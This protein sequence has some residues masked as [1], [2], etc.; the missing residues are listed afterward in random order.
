MLCAVGSGSRAAMRDIFTRTVADG[1]VERTCSAWSTNT[2]RLK[3]EQVLRQPN[4]AVTV[5][6]TAESSSLLLSASGD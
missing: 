3:H 4:R 6:A 1:W 2:H 5:C